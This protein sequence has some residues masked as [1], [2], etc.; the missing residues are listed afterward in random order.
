MSNSRW[1]SAPLDIRDIV[2]NAAARKWG[3]VVLPEGEDPR[4][5]AAASTLIRF[6]MARV[7]LLGD[8][9][10]IETIAGDNRLELRG[11]ELIQPADSPHLDEYAAGLHRLRKH[12]GV[13][14]EDALDAMH[15]PIYYGAMMLRS[16][17]VDGLVAGCCNVTARVVRAC[18][19]VIGTAPN[20]RTV[21]SCTIMVLP[22]MR[23]G[24]DGVLVFADTGVVP[25]PSSDQLAEIAWS[26]AGMFRSFLRAEPHV[27]MISFSTKGSA[28]HPLAQKVVDATGIARER[29]PE[30]SL[31]GELQVDAALLP[32]VAR[33]KAPDSPVAGKA[34]VLIF[35]DLNVGNSGYKL[36]ERLA[37]AGAYGPL[38]QGLAKPVSD[39][40]R[41]CSAEDIVDITCFVL[42]QADR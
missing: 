38:L 1:S 39:L 30:L 20:I 2:R 9:A 36:V 18:I 19:Q 34:N 26:T 17:R 7:V 28:S 24:Y 40:S 25:E 3:R 27:A 6:R 5:V 11:A 21:S 35:P 16:G 33:L 12:K 10:T 4:V 29:W 8:P 37:G 42:A 32:E 15:D 14:M 41:G 31:D 23:F 13:S 22:Q